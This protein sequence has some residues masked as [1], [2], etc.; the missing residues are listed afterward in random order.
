MGN[1]LEQRQMMS[2]YFPGSVL[3]QANT[4][5][6]GYKQVFVSLAGDKSSPMYP[7]YGGKL[8]NPFKGAAKMFAGDL[9]EY[10]VNGECYLLKTYEVSKATSTAEVFI[11]S[12]ACEYGEVFRHIPFVGDNLMVAPDAIDGTGKAVTV[13]AVEKTFASNGMQDGWKVTLSDNLGSIQKGAV[14]VEAEKAGA[15]EK[16][17]VT[18]PNCFL[19][20]DYDCIFDPSTAEEDYE[21]AKYLFSP[22]LMLGREFAWISKMSPLPKSVLAL[23]K[24]KVPEWY[25]L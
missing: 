8:K 19:E 7:P 22:S 14:L 11:S 20:N 18:N 16:A 17:M 4:K 12:G 21:G 9:V 13:I 23:N 25:Q 10:R 3:A 1:F 2:G 6:G 24:S 5:L 15:S